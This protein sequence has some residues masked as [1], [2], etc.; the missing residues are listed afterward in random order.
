MQAEILFIGSSEQYPS[1]VSA[2]DSAATM[3][4]HGFMLKNP[5]IRGSHSTDSFFFSYGMNLNSLLLKHLI[6]FQNELMNN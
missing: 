4:R 3:R 2:F 6:T 1:A 5:F